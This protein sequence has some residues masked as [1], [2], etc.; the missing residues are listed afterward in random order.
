MFVFK[1]SPFNLNIPS[2]YL[3]YVNQDSAKSFSDQFWVLKLFSNW[4]NLILGQI[5]FQ[6]SL[7]DYKDYM[8]KGD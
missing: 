2:R 5:V 6:A 4:I 7:G 3:G 1:T 8:S